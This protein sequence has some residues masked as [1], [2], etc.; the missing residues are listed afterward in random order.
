[1]PRKAAKKGKGLLDVLKKGV[2]VAKQ[3]SDLTGIKPSALLATKGPAGAVAASLLSSQ[4]LGKKKAKRSPKKKKGGCAA[5]ACPKAAQYG[6][7]F[8]DDFKRGFAMPFQGIGELGAA[9]V[10]GLLGNGKRGRR[11]GGAQCSSDMP[12]PYPNSSTVPVSVRF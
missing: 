3:V 6:Q 10:G 4:G 2:A 11:R 5:G 12:S 8:W 7:G 9:A 1:M